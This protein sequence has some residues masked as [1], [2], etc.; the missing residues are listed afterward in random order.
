MVTDYVTGAMNGFEETFDSAQSPL[1][2]VTGETTSGGKTNYLRRAFYSV[3]QNG[4]IIQC[5]FMTLFHG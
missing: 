1:N 2:Q 5:V 3:F 4:K